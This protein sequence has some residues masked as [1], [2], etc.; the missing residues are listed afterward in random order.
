MVPDYITYICNKL[1]KT[2]NEYGAYLKSKY[3]DYIKYISK[4]KGGVPVEILDTICETEEELISLTANRDGAFNCLLEISQTVYRRMETTY[5][6]GIRISREEYMNTSRCLANC[7][8]SV[9]PCNK[10]TARYIVSEVAKELNYMRGTSSKLSQR[11][12][13]YLSEKEFMCAC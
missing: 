8:R 12:K 5:G 9:Q 11:F 1:R 2:T 6:K 13:A 7:L 3:E 4:A 10:E